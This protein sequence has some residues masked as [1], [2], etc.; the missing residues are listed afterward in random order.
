MA[1]AHPTSGPPTSNQHDANGNER[2][3]HDG[4]PTMGQGEPGDPQR[5]KCQGCM[6]GQTSIPVPGWPSR[7][8]RARVESTCWTTPLASARQRTMTSWRHF[9]IRTPIGVMH[10]RLWRDETMSEFLKQARVWKHCCFGSLGRLYRQP[11]EIAKRPSSVSAEARHMMCV[12]TH[13][14]LPSRCLS[15]RASALPRWSN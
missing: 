6:Q 1:S 3:R 12:C 5:H 13:A 15:R 2:R 9:W 7:M 4:G 8:Q 10:R 11:P 14:F